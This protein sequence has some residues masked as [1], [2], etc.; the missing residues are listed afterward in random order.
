ML[1]TRICD[2]FGIE[3]PI[4]CAGMGGIACA[5]LAAAV[6]EAGGLGTIGLAAFSHEGIRNE[7]A[8][9]KMRTHKPLA[10][11]L[12]VPFLRPGIVEAVA[13]TGLTAVTFFWGDPRAHV[14][15]I[16]RLHNSGAK[17]IWQ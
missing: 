6:S 10:G 11:N 2:L 14:D 16:G 17:V 1:H 9:A 13:D 8:A 12:L 4:I 5:E 3:F 15:A 7:I